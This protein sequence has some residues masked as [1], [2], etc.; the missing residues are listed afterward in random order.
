[1]VIGSIYKHPGMP[2]NDF[3]DFYFAPV[4]DNKVDKDLEKLVHKR[5]IKFLNENNIIY[6]KQFGFR[7]KH[8]TVHGIVTL[9]ED[10]Y[11]SIDEVI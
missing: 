10:I 7:A 4:S 11:N 3:T 1:M 2:V 5:M 6:N 9:T 8:S